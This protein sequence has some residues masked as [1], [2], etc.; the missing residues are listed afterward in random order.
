MND[1]KNGTTIARSLAHSLSFVLPFISTESVGAYV[2][3]CA[4]FVSVSS[5]KMH[6][7]LVFCRL[8][9]R[10]IFMGNIISYKDC[11]KP[12]GYYNLIK[13]P[14]I[15]HARFIWCAL[16]VLFASWIS[17]SIYLT[18]AVHEILLFV[19]MLLYLVLLLLLALLLFFCRWESVIW[20]A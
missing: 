12:Y 18:V 16:C 15:F 6:F 2:C 5:T 8:R 20:A 14:C 3:V 10:H 17:R 4:L 19:P 1:T 7:M 11:C 13:F 9:A